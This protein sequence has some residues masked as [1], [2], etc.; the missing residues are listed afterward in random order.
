MK[1]VL[2]FVRNK[3]IFSSLLVLLYILIL[4]ESDVFTLIKRNERVQSLESEIERKKTGI[5][6][7]KASINQLQDIRSLEKYARENHFFKKE[8]E[9]LFIFSFE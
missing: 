3:Y 6:E 8:D 4:H 7:L 2:V 5:E 9:D 1:Q